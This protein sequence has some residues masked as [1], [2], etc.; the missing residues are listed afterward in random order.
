MGRRIVIMAGGTGGHIFPALAVAERLRREGWTVSWLGT[1]KG[2]EAKVIPEHN[3]EIDWLSVSGLRGKGLRSK[4]KSLFYLIK[5]CWQA[6]H[7]LRQ[8]KPNVVLGMGGFVA[9]PGGMMAKLLGIPLVIHEQNRVV[10]TTNKLLSKVTTQALEAFPESFSAKVKALCTGNPLR[11]AFI[12]AS[13]MQHER[14]EGLLKIAVIGGSQGA[15]VLNET[16]PPA[17][18]DLKNIQV[19]HQTGVAMQKEVESAYKS[20]NIKA[21][22]EAFIEDITSVYQWADCVICRAGAMTVSE[23]SACGL[24]AIF[25]PLPQAIDDHQSAN[26]RYLTDDN[27]A[28]L[29]TQKDLSPE[30]LRVAITKVSKNLKTM[31]ERSKDKA[32][33]K[34]T[35][36][37]ARICIEVAA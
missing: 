10:G 9:A 26:A 8:R 18:A 33:L 29:L 12:K 7:I 21:D 34:A 27:A 25:V 37:V 3:I 30:T 16:V 23:V 24:P 5:A 35:D 32:R 31:S 36:D 19:K 22:V 4:F 1:K 14:E 6:F 11:E 28:L 2:L 17:L 20:L 13:L 15:K